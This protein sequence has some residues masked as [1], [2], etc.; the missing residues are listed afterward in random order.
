MRWYFKRKVEYKPGKVFG[1]GGES[2]LEKE[3]WGAVR[4]LDQTTGRMEWE[5]RT[6][7]PLWAGVLATQG[8]LVFGGSDEG[9]VYALDARNGEP[10]WQFQAG[11]PIVTNPISFSADGTQY[12]VTAGGGAYFAFALR[13]D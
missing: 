6:P 9:N 11:G 4:A 13:Q 12:V 10:L 7:T 5:F 3:A 8:G 1:G 2:P